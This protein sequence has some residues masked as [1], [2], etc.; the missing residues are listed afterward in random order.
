MR[1]NQLSRHML[2]SRHEG[3]E[4]PVDG[5]R[6][7]KLRV[8]T[9]SESNSM[10]R[11]DPVM[12]PEHLKG[13]ASYGEIRCALSRQMPLMRSRICCCPL[14]INSALHAERALHICLPYLKAQ[15]R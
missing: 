3:F 11:Q 1:P 2:K 6:G 7:E 13:Q 8:E 14:S 4:L 10:S 15:V 12:V 9:C 5:V